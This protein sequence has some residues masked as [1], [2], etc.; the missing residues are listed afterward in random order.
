M[1]AGKQMT[2]I[3]TAARRR[4][5]GGE[6]LSDQAFE[7]LHRAITRCELVPGEIVSEPQLEQA[8]GLGRV[9][10]RLAIDRLIQLQL[11]KPIHR[12]GFEIAPIRMSDVRNTFELRLLIEPPLVKMAAGSVDVAE[13][14]RI[15]Q[16]IL[17]KPK[18]GDRSTEA[19]VID[20]NREFHLRVIQGCG[21]DKIIAIINQLL[22]DIDRFYYYGLMQ[23]PKFAEMQDQHGEMIDALEAGNGARAERLARKHVETGYQIVMDA[24]MQSASLGGAA[25]TPP[26]HPP[27]SAVG[28][29]LLT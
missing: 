8:F 15:N 16:R 20:A 27:L 22:S 1:A 23:H 28:G 19:I 12:R 24:I 5:V 3:N 7:T 18:S 26:K 13:L 9:G 6:R 2:R 14:R 25:I 17:M 10:I 29:R 4:P 21:N 11:V